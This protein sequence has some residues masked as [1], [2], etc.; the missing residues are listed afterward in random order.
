MLGG[1]IEAFFHGA[2]RAFACF[3]QL[4]ICC[5][6]IRDAGLQNGD[7]LLRT[8]RCRLGQFIQQLVELARSFGDTRLGRLGQLRLSLARDTGQMAAVSKHF[9]CVRLGL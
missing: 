3:Q 7:R 6:R 2:D 1:F 8:R 5:V 4:F 9:L